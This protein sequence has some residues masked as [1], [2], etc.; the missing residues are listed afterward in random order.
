MHVLDACPQIHVVFQKRSTITCKE[1]KCKEKKNQS[2]SCH[3][4]FYK[5]NHVEI[6][7]PVF[8]YNI[9]WRRALYSTLIF[10]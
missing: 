10:I 5:S 9:C 7:Q 4:R 3:K 2:E 6:F 1:G 8:A